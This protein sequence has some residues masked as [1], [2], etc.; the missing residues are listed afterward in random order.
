[1]TRQQTKHTHQFLWFDCETTGL[2]GRNPPEPGDLEAGGQLLE[3]ALV[4]AEDDRSGRHISVKEYTAVI[5]HDPNA[6]AMSDFVRKMHTGNG[7]LADV[8]TSPTTLAQSDD[9][10][11]A[12][13]QDLTDKPQPRDL[14]LAGNSVHFDLAWVRKHLPKFASCLS[15]RVFD[16]S[17][18]TRVCQSWLSEDDAKACKAE[19]DAVPPIHRAL[20]D[21]RAS[22]A[23][24]LIFKDSVVP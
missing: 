8:A 13:C 2:L 3:W 20:D 18:L 9:F 1:M 11:F 24:A 10:L 19:F 17:T 5:H 12:V 23:C 7:L 16:V 14:T 6:L 22:L 15:H 4:L 21:V